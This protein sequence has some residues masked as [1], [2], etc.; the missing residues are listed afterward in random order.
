MCILDL[1]VDDQ[2]WVSRAKRILYIGALDDPDIVARLLRVELHRANGKRDFLEQ[3]RPPSTGTL[4]KLAYYEAILS[5]CLVND[6]IPTWDLVRRGKR[7]SR[8]EEWVIA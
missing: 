4:I 8:E 1:T 6:P 7:V 5:S 2:W 3:E